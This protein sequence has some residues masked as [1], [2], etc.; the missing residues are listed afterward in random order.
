MICGTI[1]DYRKHTVPGY[2]S[3][4]TH[5]PWPV[6]I[7]IRRGITYGCCSSSIITVKIATIPAVSS[8]TE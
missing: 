8:R 7:Y 3:D 2:S 5:G 4:A 6:Q 1:E